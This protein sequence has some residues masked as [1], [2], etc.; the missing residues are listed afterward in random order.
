MNKNTISTQSATEL[1]IGL[2]NRSVTG[3]QTKPQ[4]PPSFPSDQLSSA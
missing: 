2:G 4:P 3:E 1:F